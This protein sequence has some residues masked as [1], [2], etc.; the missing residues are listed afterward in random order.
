MSRIAKMNKTTGFF[1]RLHPKI[2]CVFK[3]QLAIL[4]CSG[5]TFYNRMLSNGKELDETC[6]IFGNRDVIRQAYF[7]S[8]WQVENA[9]GRMRFS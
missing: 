3:G 1:I 9:T 6:A 4:S 8:R 2:D 5:N 7:R